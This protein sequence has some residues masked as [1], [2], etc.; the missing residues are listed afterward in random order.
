MFPQNY[1][2]ETTS[3]GTLTEKLQQVA[4]TTRT[5]ILSRR[6]VTAYDG[7]AI[8]TPSPDLLACIAEL[9]TAAKGLFTWLSRYLLPHSAEA[10]E[11]AWRD[12]KARAT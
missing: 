2:L 6:K 9:I 3:L 11:R 5:L 1:E 4:W 10:R 7:E 8:E 12:W